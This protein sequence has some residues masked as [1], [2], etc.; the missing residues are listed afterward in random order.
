MWRRQCDSIKK[1]PT[2]VLTEGDTIDPGGE[3]K[4][5]GKVIGQLNAS[6]QSLVNQTV[7]LGWVINRSFWRQ[8]Y[9]F[10]AT[11][12]FMSHLVR[13]SVVRKIIANI[14]VRNPESARLA[15]KPGMRLDGKFKRAT[16]EK[17]EWC[18]IWLYALLSENMA[19]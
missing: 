8:G 7:E 10:E 12:A 4:S 15:E 9:A 14:D 3:L 1:M 17:G 11:K 2:A 6:L 18:D 13:Q 16:S 5:T 19:A